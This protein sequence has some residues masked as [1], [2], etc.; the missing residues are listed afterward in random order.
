MLVFLRSI[1][2]T[3][4]IFYAFYALLMLDSLQK[5]RVVVSSDEE[6]FWLFSEG[7]YYLVKSFYVVYFLINLIIFI[8]LIKRVR[9]AW[10]AAVVLAFLSLNNSGL[11]SVVVPVGILIC[12]F[13]SRSLG[14][15]R[16]ERS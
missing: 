12:A 11:F 13:R 14:W 4:K 1:P 3:V 8:G 16:E 9:N 7:S 10:G 15:F 6:K 2:N 5:A